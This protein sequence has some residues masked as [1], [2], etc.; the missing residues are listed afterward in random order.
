MGSR[1]RSASSIPVGALTEADFNK[2][3]EDTK[4][5]PVSC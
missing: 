2:V 5:T 3:F 1:I 4:P